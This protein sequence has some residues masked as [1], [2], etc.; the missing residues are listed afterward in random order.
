MVS[1]RQVTDHEDAVQKE[2][3]RSVYT[4]PLD[5][6]SPAW[7]KL[8]RDCGVKCRSDCRVANTLFFPYCHGFMTSITYRVGC[9]LVRKASVE[10][11]S[12]LTMFDAHGNL[13]HLWLPS[14][15]H[16]TISQRS[17]T[18]SIKSLREMQQAQ[19]QV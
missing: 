2:L 19:A 9:Y 12:S 3:E 18:E 1:T 6:E 13:I 17:S 8:G 11:I 16:A 5:R 14:R 10:Q 15:H 4:A 7:R